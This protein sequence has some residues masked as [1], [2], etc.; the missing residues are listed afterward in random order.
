[1][2]LPVPCR[3]TSFLANIAKA[4]FRQICF[5][6]QCLTWTKEGL[7]MNSVQVYAG[8]MFPTLERLS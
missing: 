7:K 8:R 4:I 5:K 1:M 2:V 6:G 3:S